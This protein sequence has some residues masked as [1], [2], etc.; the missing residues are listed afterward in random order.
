MNWKKIAKILI[1][2]IAKVT[3][4]ET[5]DK[6]ISVGESPFFE[7]SASLQGSVED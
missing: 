2:N 5:I 7:L 3:G 1:S 6:I 4:D